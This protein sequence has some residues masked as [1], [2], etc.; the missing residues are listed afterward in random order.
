M[1][2]TS[3]S[4]EELAARARVEPKLVGLSLEGIGEAITAGRPLAG[5][6]YEQLCAE[7]GLPLALVQRVHEASGLGRPQPGDP[8]HSLDRDLLAS[9]QLGWGWRTGC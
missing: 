3:F 5:T 6:T 1:E 4:E 8:I 7:L 9:T 2:E